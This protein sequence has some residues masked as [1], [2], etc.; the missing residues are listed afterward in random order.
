MRVLVTGEAGLI[1]FNVSRHLLARGDTVLGIDSINDYYDPHIKRD[2]LALLA[3]EHAFTFKQ[4]DSL[5]MS[6]S[7]RRWTARRSTASCT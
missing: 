7:R 4:V 2:R 5:T 6:H 3:E 1:G